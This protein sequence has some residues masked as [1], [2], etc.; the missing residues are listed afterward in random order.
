MWRT[1]HVDVTTILWYV[2]SGISM[3]VRIDSNEVLIATTIV[4]RGYAGIFSVP[5]HSCT[6]PRS[7]TW[8]ILLYSCNTLPMICH[9]A[10]QMVNNTHTL[11]HKTDQALHQCVERSKPCHRYTGKTTINQLSKS[12][13]IQN[14]LVVDIIPLCHSCAWLLCT[15]VR[16]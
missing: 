14:A 3:A 4:Y 1:V 16:N 6:L 12:T 9:I 5:T 10:L 8:V 13:I 7:P 2:Y 11:Q 15:Q